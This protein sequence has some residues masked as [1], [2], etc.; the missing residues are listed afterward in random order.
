MASF[1]DRM[2]S[3][4]T[5]KVMT[6]SHVFQRK[7]TINTD[8]PILNIAFSGEVDGGLVPG[9]TVI[10]GPSKSFKSLLTL[11]CLKAFQDKYPDGAAIFYDCEYGIT[12]DYMRMV[13]VDPDRVI[14]EEIE[15]VEDLKFKIVKL[16]R[17]EVELGDKVFIMI[18]SIGNLASIKELEDA[19]NAKSVADMSRARSLKS[20]F[21]MITPYLT[22]KSIP[23]IAINHI[24][25]EMGLY[26]KA[27]VS[28]GT[29]VMYSANQVFIMGKSQI[30]DGTEIVGYDF[31]INIEKSRFV[32]EKSKLP[33]TVL[34]NQGIQ[35]W[36]S[37]FE[38]AAESGFIEKPKVGWYTTIDPETGEVSPT[39]LRKAEIEK[40]DA[41]F[42]KLI[43]ND[44]FKEYVESK[45]KLG[46]GET[47][48]SESD[49]INSQ[50]EATL[51]EDE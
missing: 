10:A 24:Y 37:M 4:K 7:E 44:K 14:Y 21:R 31:T 13:G 34:N 35:K 47:N 23:C 22:K 11:Y 50:I 30:K 9:L 1:F 36:S 41:F 51:G 25:M 20:L 6:D 27:I 12:E 46:N 43:K 18:D 17:E 39:N 3:K 40:N 16:L 2:K 8:L 38:L 28:G 42:N 15:N 49:D 19:T 32:R 45:F 48:P 33:F 26:P 5:T 29:G